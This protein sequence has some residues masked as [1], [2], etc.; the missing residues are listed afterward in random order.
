MRHLLARVFLA[1][2]ILSIICGGANSVQAAGQDDIPIH[3]KIEKYF[4][5]YTHPAPP[6]VDANNRLLIPLPAIQDLMGGTV[7]YDSLTKTAHISLLHHEFEV[8]IN[9]QIATVDNRTITMDTTPIIK[10]GSMF[11][12]IR[13][14]LDHTDAEYT[15]DQQLHLL[16]ITDERLAAGQPFEDFIGN[17]YTLGH[18]DGAFQ[19]TSFIMNPHSMSIT[20]RNISGRD[21]AKGKVDIHPLV[22]FKNGGFSTDAY[23]KPSYPDLPAVKK[24]QSITITRPL[25]AKNTMYMISVGR[26]VP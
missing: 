11:L 12:P 3:L 22:S 6:F 8:A 23:S 16:H 7:S 24:D 4:I 20:A 17:D 19:L 5:L 18:I 26:Q 21:I 13:L 25:D 9:S 14:F 2:F 10:Q 1:G 15:W